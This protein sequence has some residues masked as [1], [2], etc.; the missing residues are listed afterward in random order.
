MACVVPSKFREKILFEDFPQ[1][2]VMPDVKGR[3]GEAFTGK[4]HIFEGVPDMLTSAS[5]FQSSSTSRTPFG[6]P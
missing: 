3:R 5:S 2:F 6:K 4:Y 1:L